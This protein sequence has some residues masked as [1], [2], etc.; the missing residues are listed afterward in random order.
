LQHEHG[1]S[2]YFEADGKRILLDTGLS[3]KALS[4][5]Q[6]LGIDVGEIDWLILSHGHVDHTGGLEAFLQQNEKASIY[7][8]RHILTWNYFSNHHGNQHS[9][10][11]NHK[12]IQQN[13]QRF[14]LLDSHLQLSPQLWLVF[15]RCHDFP[16]PKG[17]Q[18]LSLIDT[19]GSCIPYG[20]E[21]E[22]SVA[23]VENQHLHIL[24]SCS[25]NGILNIIRSC[26]K[27][28]GISDIATYIGGLHLL[29]DSE[30][31]NSLQTL[32]S[33]ILKQYPNLSL[34]TGHCTGTHAKDVL[35]KALKNQFHTFCTGEMIE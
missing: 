3:G 21:D 19:Q 4:N 33:E 17:N 28:T 8:S 7:A 12:L 35:Q 6:L 31:E 22:I 2:I 26:Q 9:L 14:H 20:A 34:H 29:D 32:A 1:L 11:P 18:Y 25:H 24:A 15:N 13:L 16:V 30:S 23:I 10:N 27:V 5:A